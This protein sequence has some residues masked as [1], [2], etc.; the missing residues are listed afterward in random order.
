MMLKA[1]LAPRQN[2]LAL[3]MVVL[4]A[5]MASKAWALAAV[6]SGKLPLWLIEGQLGF[7]FSWNRGMSF[8]LLNGVP[9][10]PLLLAGVAVVAA[11]WFTHWLNEKPWPS[12]HQAGLSCIIGGALGN[13]IDRITHG[14]VVDFLVLNPLHLF[15]Y[16]FNIADAAI[17]AG[18]AALLLDMLLNRK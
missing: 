15:P 3:G 17:T 4:M 9:Y 16:T 2:A 5:D 6:A 13:L 11:A 10:A 14:A 8:S 1:Y 18:V 7:A 12:L